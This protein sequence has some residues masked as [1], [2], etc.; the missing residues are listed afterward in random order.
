M[1]LT[2]DNINIRHSI[3]QKTLT[4]LQIF[5]LHNH[6]LLQKKNIF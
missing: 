2:G 5:F 6:K 3:F 1:P 4:V